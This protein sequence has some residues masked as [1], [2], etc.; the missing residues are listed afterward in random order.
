[1]W[2]GDANSEA[3]GTVGGGLVKYKW[4]VD[5]CFQPWSLKRDDSL[6]NWKVCALLKGGNCRSAL[7]KCRKIQIFV[8]EVST[9]LNAGNQFN[10]QI[11]PA[12]L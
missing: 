2:W 11:T 5:V 10:L 6:G 7:L 9:F 1:M 8:C 12:G 4:I 3:F